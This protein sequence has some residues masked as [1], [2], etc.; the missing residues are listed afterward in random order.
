MPGSPYFQDYKGMIGGAV[1]PGYA[2]MLQSQSDSIGEGF[3]DL[4]AGIG[5]AIERS[6]QEKAA[7]KAAMSIL[8]AME[9][10]EPTMPSP[11]AM[12]EY[13]SKLRKWRAM[14][15]QHKAMSA[16]ERIGSVKGIVEAMV[17]QSKLEESRSRMATDNMQRSQIQQAVEEARELQSPRREAILTQAMENRARAENIQ[18][19]TLG[20]NA[21]MDVQK[22]EIYPGASVWTAGRNAGLVVDPSVRY[23]QTTTREDPAT[24]S[25]RQF[26]YN[27]LLDLERQFAEESKKGATAN[28]V[29]LSRI[30]RQ[31]DSAKKELDKLRSGGQ[32]GGGKQII[33]QLDAQ[34]NLGEP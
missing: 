16:N 21:G 5:R 22:T 29:T 4:N 15:D 24:K 10:P 3:R 30:L 26:Q 14:N 17:M 31:I 18:A 6:K 27:R 1:P 34:G 11:E 9:P 13:E 19:D 25:E 23:G 8:A 28:S 33:Y 12:E 32:A 7:D 20:T 2:Q